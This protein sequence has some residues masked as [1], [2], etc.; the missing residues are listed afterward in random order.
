MEEFSEEIKKFLYMSL[1]IFEQMLDDR[2]YI[3]LYSNIP[4]IDIIERMNKGK[5][6]C[7]SGKYAM[8]IIAT[9][10]KDIKV[11]T[12]IICDDDYETIICIYTNNINISH[13]KM[14]KIFDYKIEIWPLIFVN[15]SSHS[16]QPKI[17][18]IN[19]REFKLTK[20]NP[21]KLPKISY[22][23]PL[24]RYYRIPHKSIIK[25]TDFDSLV[26]YRL[27]I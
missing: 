23:D 27:V 3:P 12:D 13:K 5:Y 1:P 15:I 17:E 8:T 19:Q 6:E 4:K 26:S 7:P 11:Y 9:C 10:T 16:L 24:I 20:I 18:T 2:K 14:E 25:I 21:L 22:Y